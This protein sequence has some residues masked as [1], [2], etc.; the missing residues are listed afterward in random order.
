MRRFALSCALVA[1]PSS[2]FA[3]DIHLEDSFVPKLAALCDAARYASRMTAEPICNELAAAVQRAIA[4]EA[5]KK[6]D[7]PKG[8][9]P[10]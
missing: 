4:E 5:N 1:L 8:D 7:T 2:A 9:A 3:Y 6:G 10:K